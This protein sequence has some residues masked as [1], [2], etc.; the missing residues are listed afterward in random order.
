MRGQSTNGYG[1][2]GPA[3]TGIGGRRHLANNHK[4]P[5]FYTTGQPHSLNIHLL[6]AEM[7]VVQ[8]GG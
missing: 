7:Q 3:A 2:Y 4:H 8:N 6:G 5:G 1:V